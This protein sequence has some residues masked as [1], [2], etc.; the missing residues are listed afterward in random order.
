MHLVRHVLNGEGLGLYACKRGQ[1]VVSFLS[2][3]RNADPL[4]SVAIGDNSTRSASR[5]RPEGIDQLTKPAST[6][7]YLNCYEKSTFS[8]RFHIPTSYNVGEPT[9]ST[10]LRRSRSSLLDHHVWVEESR[11]SPYGPPIPT[12]HLLMAYANGGD[13]GSFVARRSGG[14]GDDSPTDGRDERVRRFRMRNLSSVHLL[15]LD[16]ILSI[17][18]DVCE[19]LAFLH[20]RN[21]LHLDIKVC[22]GSFG[23]VGVNADLPFLTG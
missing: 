15:R 20:S 6:T 19:G 3:S 13:L 2:E 5:R 22:R 7:G 21:I 1:S 16:E 8:R 14:P 10:E 11:L 18:E 23:G 12:L 17:F 4:R 9:S